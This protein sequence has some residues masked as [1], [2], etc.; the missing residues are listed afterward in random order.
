M[1]K[2]AIT[3]VSP[4]LGLSFDPKT[5]QQGLV[6]LQSIAKDSVVS[7]FAALEQLPAPTYLSVQVDS[8]QHIHLSPEFLRYI[9]HSCDPNI[10]LDTQTGQIIALRDITAGEELRYFYPSTEWAMSQAFN[11]GCGTAQCLGTIGGASQLPTHVLE[12][13]RLALHIEQKLQ[14]N[15]ST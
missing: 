8:N 2:P 5:Q 13:Y 4:Y 3:P 10:F 6:S 15:E 12:K 11:C 1:K 9:N 14:A 7:P